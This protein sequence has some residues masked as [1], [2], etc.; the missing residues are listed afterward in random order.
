MT[1]PRRYSPMFIDCEV[2]R[3]RPSDSFESDS[4]GRHLKHSYKGRYTRR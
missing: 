3:T 1:Y 2:V 4:I